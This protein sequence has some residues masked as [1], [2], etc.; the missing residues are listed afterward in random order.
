MKKLTSIF[1]PNCQYF[2]IGP[3]AGEKN[4]IWPIENFIEI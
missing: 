3:G 4:R 1:D 2:G